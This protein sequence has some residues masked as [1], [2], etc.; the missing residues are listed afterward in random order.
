MGKI[1]T[2]AALLARIKLSLSKKIAP[3]MGKTPTE[4]KS[5]HTHKPRIGLIKEGFYN[6]GLFR[7]F[8]RKHTAEPA[9]AKTGMFKSN[10]GR[11][12]Y[13]GYSD[14]SLRRIA[15]IQRRIKS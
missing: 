4:K 8:A 13:Q 14:G 5:K 12:T 9:K 11:A 7:I 2:L 10:D 1:D 6:K 15:T 3:R